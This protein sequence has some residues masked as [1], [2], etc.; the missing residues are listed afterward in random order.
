MLAK[1]CNM[2]LKFSFLILFLI[3]HLSTWAQLD[4]SHLGIQ[5]PIDS[6]YNQ[7][8]LFNFHNLDFMRNTEYFTPIER[9]ET[10]F[11]YDVL[12]NL[13]YYPGPKL[14]ITAGL[15]ARKDFGNDQFSIIAPFYNVKYGAN[16]ISAEVGNLEGGV[17]HRLIEPF[18]D[19]DYVITK[20]LESGFQVKIDKPWLWSDT[21]INWERMIYDNSPFKEE[22]TNGSSNYLR[23]YH[24]PNKKFSITIPIQFLMHHFGGQISTISVD[25]T[26]ITSMYTGAVGLSFNKQFNGNVISSLKSENY[27]VWSRTFTNPSLARFPFGDG[28]YLNLI[29]KSRFH[30]SCILS[31]W[32]VNDFYS[33]KGT[34]IYMSQSDYLPDFIEPKRD[35]L[36]LHFIYNREIMK[37]LFVNVRFEPYRSFDL[38]KGE[39]S[40][41]VYF[42]YT[43][44]F[45]LMKKKPMLP[46]AM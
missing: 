22:I 25:T 29:L 11:G 20:P 6:Q 24:S 3:L 44:N 45:V 32:N 41:S 21:W 13:V 36:F 14:R 31:Y 42:T 5:L 28:Y 18:Y 27:F 35:L 43:K 38:N 1:F 9:G 33:P 17:E 15:F 19:I 7:E 30:V 16:G 8:L 46:D 37:N 2:R 10:L 23:V 39:F 40:Y 26:P 4:N 12:P 34:H